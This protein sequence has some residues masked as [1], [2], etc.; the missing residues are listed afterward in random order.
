[1]P[2]S[3]QA[4]TQLCLIIKIVLCEK[5]GNY[6]SERLRQWGRAACLAG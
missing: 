3:V 2:E 4:E 1:M 5:L 6:R